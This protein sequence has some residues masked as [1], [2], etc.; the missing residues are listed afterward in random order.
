[1]RWG[2]LEEGDLIDE[3]FL[4]NV[5]R[6][7]NI[8]AVMHFA[9][10]AEVACSVQNPLMY[11]RNNVS[12]SISLLNA[13]D[14]AGISKIVFSSSD[15]IYGNVNAKLIP[16]DQPCAPISPYGYS[17]YFF[18]R[19]LTDCVNTSNLNMI[20]FRYFNVAG[21]DPDVDIGENLNLSKRLIPR[22]IDV[23]LGRSPN[24]QVFGNT[25]AT[26]DGSCIRDYIHVCDLV[27]AHMLGLHNLRSGSVNKVFNLGAGRGYSIFQ[28]IN[29]V[30]TLTGTKVSVEV[31]D[32]RIGDPTHL[33]ADCARAQSILGWRPLRSDIET[34]ISDALNWH[35]K[36]W[37]CTR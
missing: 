15:T 36:F 12:A 30:E 22:A 11:Y 13:M 10:L 5:M 28:I 2:P 3:V 34:Q 14:K 29:A 26:P 25:Y 32:K 20:I 33:V 37:G 23:A 18:E 31:C 7:Y 4:L 19:I 9:A 17:K 35:N 27:D 1:M 16:E 24:L 8:E 21:A 6:R